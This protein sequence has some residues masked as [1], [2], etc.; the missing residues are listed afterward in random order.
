M[1]INSKATSLPPKHKDSFLAM[2]YSFINQIQNL[3]FPPLSL[4]KK[5][6]KR[7]QNLIYR[8]KKEILAWFSDWNE[9]GTVLV[10]TIK[11]II[12]IH[13]TGIVEWHFKCDYLNKI[14]EFDG[15]SLIDFNLEDKIIC[16]KEFESKSDHY[17]PYSQN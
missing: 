9:K 16:I 10:W 8:N 12:I 1:T 13:Q 7:I 3:V 2:I 15:V 5:E 4:E 11:R 6:N 17:Y 14:S